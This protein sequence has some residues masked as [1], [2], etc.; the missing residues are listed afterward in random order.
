MDRTSV[1]WRIAFGC[2]ENVD[3][4]RFGGWIKE[5]VFTRA[6]FYSIDGRKMTRV[7][8]RM[9]RVTMGEKEVLN[10]KQIECQGKL[11]ENSGRE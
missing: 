6:N 10:V 2:F 3:R 4:T 7:Y 5:G 8:M 11:L 9:G 1:R